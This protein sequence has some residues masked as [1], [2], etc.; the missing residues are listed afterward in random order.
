MLMHEN[1][2][3]NN[4]QQSHHKSKATKPL[5]HD[6]LMKPYKESSFL[7]AGQVLGNGNS[8]LG[9]EVCDEVFCRN[10]A[11]KEKEAIVVSKKKTKLSELISRVKVIKDEM[12]DKFSSSLLT[13]R[14]CW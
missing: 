11:R 10:E 3:K 9:A 12:K 2:K 13:N 14:V 1:E 8:R 6:D 4:A 7:T 5:S